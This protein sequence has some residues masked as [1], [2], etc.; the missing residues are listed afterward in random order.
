MNDSAY[1]SGQ[2]TKL[3]ALM[4]NRGMTPARFQKILGSG[5]LT[6]IF[7]EKAVLSDRVAICSALKLDLERLGIYRFTVEYGKPVTE[8]LEACKKD[9]PWKIDLPKHLF[10]EKLEATMQFEGCLLEAPEGASRSSILRR[11]A[12]KDRSNPWVPADSDHML[13]FATKFPHVTQQ[14]E[15]HYIVGLGNTNSVLIRLF[16]GMGFG[17][18][19]L[20][21]ALAREWGDHA[22][23]KSN[24]F[25]AV[26]A[27]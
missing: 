24:R 12:S 5:V 9:F 27:I 14:S 2:L 6:D 3:T 21:T 8:R 10:E 23:G 17:C 4:H 13:A 18:S 19:Y 22:G 15:F 20:F 26:R 1:T 16:Q 25:L 7:D 11:T